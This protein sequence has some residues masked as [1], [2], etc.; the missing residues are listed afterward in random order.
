MRVLGLIV[1]SLMMSACATGMQGMNKD[2]LYKYADIQIAN[3][4]GATITNVQ[5]EVGPGG[6]TLACPSVLNNEL[7][8]QRFIE[9]PYPDQ[10]IQLS[11]VG[12]N[13]SQNSKQ[14]SPEI[15][16]QFPPGITLQLVINIRS[17]GSVDASLQPDDWS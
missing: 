7:C 14:L 13:G 9:I 10:P 5:I 8:Q 12:S 3:L 6:H 2:P 17:D 11:W 4:T 15:L 1:V 16:P